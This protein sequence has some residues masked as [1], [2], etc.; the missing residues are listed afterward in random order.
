MADGFLGR[1]SKRKLDAQD[2]K[3]LAP[4][5][6]EAIVPAPADIQP[7]APPPPSEAALEPPPLTLED[8]QA[9]TTESDFRPFAARGVAPEVQNAALRTLFSDPHFNVMD[10]LDTYIDDYSQPDPI[11]KEMLR[12]LASARFLGLFDAEEKE[13]AEQAAAA[14]AAAREVADN[15]TSQTVAQSA[16]APAVPSASSNDDPDLRLQ[17]DHAPPGQ[18]PGGGAA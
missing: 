13:E 2:G 1:W 18:A 8:A 14:G 5:P 16:A 9:L 10:R 4:E 11:P 15:P 6:A 12:K 7:V 17:Q 3:P